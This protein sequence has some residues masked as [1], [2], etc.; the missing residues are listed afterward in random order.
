MKTIFS[1][2]LTI[3]SF[4]SCKNQE[5]SAQSK[6]PSQRPKDLKIEWYEGGGMLPQS[7]SL[8]ISK[9]SSYI[10]YFYSQARNKVYF[11]VNENELDNLYKQLIDNQLDRIKTED[12]GTVYD[13]G[14]ENITLT[15]NGYKNRIAVGS[16]GGIFIA[17]NWVE[18]YNNCLQAIS[19]LKNKKINALK[20]PFNIVLDN[21]IIDS[22]KLIHIQIADTQYNYSS[23]K[24][25]LKGKI[26]LNI[27][28]GEHNLVIHLTENTEPSYQRKNFTFSNFNFKVNS[29]K[30]NLF[31]KLI[32]KDIQWELR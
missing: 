27:L 31:L 26:S 30:P 24:E 19:D 11:Q 8:F 15:F 32:E 23:E 7:E 2:L 3:L 6:L 17:K 20:I 18:K 29:E 16:S 21:S 12:K 13:R 4:L 1:Y 25:G 9:D 10:E 28:S 14:G 5:G 22:G